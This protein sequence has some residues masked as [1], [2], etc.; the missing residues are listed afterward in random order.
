M[1]PVTDLT[2][3]AEHISATEDLA[4]RIDARGDDEVGRMAA[5]FNTM[6]DTL[7][8]S[9]GTPSAGSWPTPRTSCA[10]R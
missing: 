1:Q 8:A 10:R 3:A 9:R 7:A 5:R 4:R 6:L 2:E